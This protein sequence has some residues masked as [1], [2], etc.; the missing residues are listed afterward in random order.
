MGRN[1]DTEWHHWKQFP[2]ASGDKLMV[3]CL[4]CGN[5]QLKNATKCREHITKCLKRSQEVKHEVKD[6]NKSSDPSLQ[7]IW[8]EY[9]HVS[10]SG[11]R[12]V[13]EC[14]HCGN[15]RLKNVTKCR[16]HI[17]KCLKKA[18]EVNKVVKSSDGELVVADQALDP[19][20]PL[21]D[22]G[23]VYIWRHWKHLSGSVVRSMVECLQCG[24]RMVK[25]ATKCQQHIAKCL[26]GFQEVKQAVEDGCDVDGVNANKPSD[27][28]PDNNWLLWKDVS[29]G[30]QSVV[31]CLHCGNRQMK[32]A[33]KCRKH[34]SKCLLTLNVRHT[35]AAKRLITSDECV[36]RGEGPPVQQYRPRVFKSVDIHDLLDELSDENK[37]LLDELK[38]AQKYIEFMQNY[39]KCL[40]VYKRKCVC[41]QTIDNKPIV[42]RLESSYEDIKTQIQRMRTQS[43]DD[44][45]DSE[46]ESV[47][48]RKQNKA[49]IAFNNTFNR[50]VI[51]ANSQMVATD[52]DRSSVGGDFGDN[53]NPSDD[54]YQDFEPEIKKK[55]VSREHT[56]EES[57]KC[58]V[59]DRI[60]TDRQYFREH[61]AIHAV[62]QETTLDGDNQS[63]PS[64]GLID[65]RRVDGRLRCQWRDCDMTFPKPFQ[66]WQHYRRKHTTIRP[67][68]C[69]HCPKAVAFRK[70]LKQHSNFCT[71]SSDR[72]DADRRLNY[73]TADDSHECY[74]FDC[75]RVFADK[76]SLAR[77]TIEDHKYTNNKSFACDWPECG[78]AFR[79]YRAL[80]IH[81]NRDHINATSHVCRQCG[82]TF[83]TDLNLKAHQ[84]R[85]VELRLKN[86]KRK[87][88]V[89]DT[90]DDHDSP[91]AAQ[92]RRTGGE[93]VFCCQ[94]PDCGHECDTQS[95][96]KNH[97]NDSHCPSLPLLKP[98]A[99]IHY[100]Y[101]CEWTD[102]QRRFRRIGEL[103][104]HYRT[105]HNCKKPFKCHKCDKHFPKRHALLRH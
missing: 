93:L 57:F 23:M 3:E 99:I 67:Y 17:V 13:V 78:L 16:Q 39:R 91:S 82:A 20:P 38:F 98:Q 81:R 9:K 105:D 14:L 96:L 100:Q 68:K 85:C 37:R 19:P 53:D 32:N 101:G 22:N 10:G 43:I 21:L 104:G 69:P 71:K 1:Q 77:H 74:I 92:K 75:Q 48:K 97:I 46:E 42:Q 2:T 56:N 5:K 26:K 6:A 94:Y 45:R 87:A 11:V 103:Q 44:Y 25:N 86:R 52:D 80:E 64:V 89:E 76:P 60:Y 73:D 88:V 65:Y 63:N 41:V 28:L 47:A 70:D 35:L 49:L 79:Q 50:S 15:R 33:T 31:E 72:G 27:P 62:K 12:S 18:Q 24:N 51:L 36:D 29:S 90:D 55:S 83:P 40:L 54:S 66:M 58:Q 7:N 95:Q 34:T 61:L 102:C 84:K 4:H 8:L 30:V 59:C